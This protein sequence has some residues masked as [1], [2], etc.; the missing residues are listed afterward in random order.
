MAATIVSKKLFDYE[1]ARKNGVFT[2]RF[3]WELAVTISQTWTDMLP[4]VVATL[5]SDLPIEGNV[6]PSTATAT[7]RGVSCKLVKG[8]VYHYTAEY[9]DENADAGTAATSTDPTDDLPIIRPVGGIRERAIHKDRDDEAMLNTAGDPVL[10]TIEDNTIDIVVEVNVP[11][12]GTAEALVLNLRNTT[13]DAPFQIG[14]WYVGTNMAR[15]IFPT[16]FLSERKKRNS[17]FYKVFK[18]ELKIDERDK[19]YGVPLNAGFRE[20]AIDDV[21]PPAVFHLETI[22]EK[23]GS[24]PSEPVPLASSGR[25]LD[26]PSPETVIYLEF[27]KYI[28]A[29]FTDL[30]GVVSWTP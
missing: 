18:Y 11:D 2:A 16:D 1:A 3:V 25:K 22:L 29:D 26:N 15:V 20:K 9:S 21:G 5:W 23:D 4:E 7:C 17:T 14:R 8:G 13:N 24:E 6:H 19:H 10:Q 12:N 27:K 30:P 28:E